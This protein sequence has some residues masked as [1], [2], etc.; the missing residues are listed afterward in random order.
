MRH[1]TNQVARRP[2]R[3][4]GLRLTPGRLALAV[5]RLPL[6][7][8]RHGAGW[9]FGRTFLEFTH[10]GRTTGRPHNA[11][12]MVLH[13]DEATREAV[14]CA[15]WGARTDWYRN[16]QAGPA[17]NVQLGRDSYPPGQRFLS[18]DEAFDVGVG[19]RRGH[20]H[21][22][23]L[24]SNVLGWGDLDD[25]EAL[26]QFVHSHPFV[27]FRPAVTTG[28]DAAQCDAVRWRRATR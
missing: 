4:L 27:A 28:H 19:F 18:D 7:A 16:L 3:L 6:H 20:P 22:L 15:A 17:V 12:A 1:V 21:R 26:R 25:D 24:L 9:L 8:Y 2:R 23:R 14:I 11:I 5:F 13:Y 10:T